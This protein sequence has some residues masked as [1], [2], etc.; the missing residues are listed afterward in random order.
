MKLNL[1]LTT[2]TSR[3]G[4]LFAYLQKKREDQKIVRS[5]EIGGTF[6]FI[7]FF[8]LF[9]IK[10]TFLTISTLLGDIKAKEVLSKE[11]K[12]K[13]NDVIVAQDL[14]SQVQERYSLVESSLPLNLRLY[15]ANSQIL[16]STSK[17]QLSPNKIDYII[18]KDQDN[19]GATINATS[20]FSSALSMVSDLLQNRRLIDLDKLSFSINDEMVGQINLNMPLKIYYWK[21]NVKK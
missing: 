4:P 1:N 21:D 14:F 6:F 8:I 10:P 13:I 7:S 19:Y 5:V 16:G 3:M 11:L 20:N 18:T 2:I 17:F 12:T 9:A 15:Q